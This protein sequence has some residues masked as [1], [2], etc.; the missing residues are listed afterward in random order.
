MTTSSKRTHP[1]NE[2]KFTEPDTDLVILEQR[3]QQHEVALSGRQRYRRVASTATINAFIKPTTA[4]DKGRKALRRKNTDKPSVAEITTVSKRNVAMLNKQPRNEA[5]HNKQ[6]TYL[7]L[8]LTLAPP[9]MRILAT[10]AS[11]G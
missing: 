3:L 5:Y 1:R 8:M 4:K 7:S 2:S 11:S 6:H 9:S 10:L